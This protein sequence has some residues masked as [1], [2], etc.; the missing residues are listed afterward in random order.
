MCNKI[1][2]LVE[3][4]N[5]NDVQPYFVEW[6]D[7]DDSREM[8]GNR[9]DENLTDNRNESQQNQSF[10]QQRIQIK[11]NHKLSLN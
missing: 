6:S 3:E 5:E 11:L 10:Q 2:S 7:G 4:R 9:D 8:K 1:V